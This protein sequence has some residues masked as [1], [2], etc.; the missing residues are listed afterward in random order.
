MNLVTRYSSFLSHN[1]KH[2]DAVNKHTSP[3]LQNIK[4]LHLPLEAK[5]PEYLHLV[6]FSS[7]PLSSLAPS[8]YTMQYVQYNSTHHDL[9]PGISSTWSKGNSNCSFSA[10]DKLWPGND[11]GMECQKVHLQKG[12]NWLDT[13]MTG[14]KDSQYRSEVSLGSEACC[15]V[16]TTDHGHGC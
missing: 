1:R 10:F 2:C 7:A 11:L 3:L 9:F 5:Y 16:V 4:L 14:Q 12:L 8:I 13:R 15:S 6:S